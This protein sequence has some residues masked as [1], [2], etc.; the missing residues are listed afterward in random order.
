M[1]RSLAAAVALAAALGLAG[2]PARA[3]EQL[4]DGIAAQ[5][6][7]RIVL[8]S[9]V[10]RLVAPQEAA[11][12]AAGA[13]ESEIAKLRASGLERMIETRLV[14]EVVRQHELFASDEEVDKTIEQIAKEN[15]LSLEQLYASVA[16]H[17]MTKDEYRAQI[18]SEIERRNVINGM[19]GSKIT[20]DEAQVHKL[21]DE[22]FADQPKGGK[23]AHVRQLLVTYGG[24]SKRT[25]DQAC[26]AAQSARQ[27][28]LGGEDFKAVAGEVS[29]VAPRDG[30]DIGWLHLDTVADWMHSALATMKPGSISDVLVLP[31]GCSVLQL[32]EERDFKPVTYENARSALTQELWE[33]ELEKGYRKWLDELRKETYIDRRGYFAEAARFEGV[34]LPGGDEQPPGAASDP[35]GSSGALSDPFASTP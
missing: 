30:G 27:R 17:G 28:V 23:A 22:R 11:M 31:F 20:I 13:P 33:R 26:A 8:F 21:Y 5:V 16:F 24:M 34:T 6:G 32:V 12:R 18:K 29:E 19:I 15:G 14:E 2:P 35:S 10:M 7:S 9:E 3:A 25:R 4:V 1:P